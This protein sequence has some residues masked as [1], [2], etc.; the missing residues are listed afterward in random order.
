M[1]E[2]APT[3]TSAALVQQ[4]CTFAPMPADV[5]TI[6]L[7]ET[8]LAVNRVS[9]ATDLPP[10][11]TVA[12]VAHGDVAAIFKAMTGTPRA[13]PHEVS[14]SCATAMGSE[15]SCRGSHGSPR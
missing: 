11:F 4:V 2:S 13:E 15:V 12:R 1:T 8:G 7:G 6:A 9:S 14:L 3:R 5:E 10:S